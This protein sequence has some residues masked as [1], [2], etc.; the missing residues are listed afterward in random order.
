MI[1]ASDYWHGDFSIAQVNSE[2]GVWLRRPGSDAKGE[3]PFIIDRAF[4]P[5]QWNSVN[6]ILRQ[7]DLRIDVDGRTRLTEHLA[8]DSTSVW[9]PGLLALG[10]EV[11]GD[12]PWQGEMRL[13]RC[14]HQAMRSIMSGAAHCR[15]RTLLL[16]PGP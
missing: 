12:G 3:P 5:R 15:S 1:L 8:A 9:T 10:N 4:R 14:A 13:L 2:L 6:L 7:G 16:L 11:H